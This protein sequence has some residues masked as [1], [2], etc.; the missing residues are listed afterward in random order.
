MNTK[1]PGHNKEMQLKQWFETFKS[2][3]GMDAAYI[4]ESIW[5]GSVAL[6]VTSVKVIVERRLFMNKLMKLTVFSESHINML[7]FAM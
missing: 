4:L 7:L 1:A 2:G 6:S 3:K 5:Q